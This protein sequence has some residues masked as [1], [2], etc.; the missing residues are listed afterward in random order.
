MFRDAQSLF[1][2][3]IEEVMSEGKMADSEKSELTDY[4]KAVSCQ[5]GD[6][7][8][9]NDPLKR[10]IYLV[11]PILRLDRDQFMAPTPA[12]L[13][14]FL[15]RVLDNLL[16]STQQEDTAFYEKFQKNK[17]DYLE[18]KVYEYLSRVFPSNCVH[19]NLKYQKD[20]EADAVVLFKNKIILVE[21]KARAF[22]ARPDRLEDD[23]KSNVVDAFS[24]TLRT[25]KYITEN[26]T[27]IF[28]DTSGNTV[29]IQYKKGRDEIFMIA[30]TFENLLTFA[31]NA[32]QLK[33]IGLLEV[34][35]LLWSVN[36]QELDLISRFLTNPSIFL[37]YIQRR[38]AA[39]EE[40]AFFGVDELS[41]L[42]WYLER[43]NFY[44]PSMEDGKPNMVGIDAGFIGVFD[45]HFQRNKPAPTL[46]IPKGYLRIIETLERV[47][48]DLYPQITSALLDLEYAQKET[49]LQILKKIAKQAR[50]DSSVHDA[51]F[52]FTEPAPTGITLLAQKGRVQMVDRMSFLALKNKYA[53]KMKKWIALGIDVDD[54][55]WFVN[56]FALFDFD[57]K[58]DPKFEQIVA[59]ARKPTK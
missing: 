14:Y 50:T 32:Q 18:N 1:R 21:A 2:F 34:G 44:V 53:S 54:N 10:N 47:G 36:I 17:A 43:G 9:Y 56:E 25:K 12:D 26:S 49:V 23:L 38:L 29:N 19:R 40:G 33:D 57:W 59:A 6:N 31:T 39:Q 52:T 37:H 7:Q 42:G 24:Q 5:K 13:V 55:D 15:P 45:D 28:R 30:A 4:L 41:Y 8:N 3:T 20:N 51:S 22:T 35:E 11:K 16:V 48:T 46:K 27:A 58:Y